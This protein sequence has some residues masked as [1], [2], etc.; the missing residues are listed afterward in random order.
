M[1]AEVPNPEYVMPRSILYSVIVIALLYMA[2]NFCI[3]IAAPWREAV[4]SKRIAGA[5]T[6]A[7]GVF[8][9]RLWRGKG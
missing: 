2:M 6:L 3:L 9:F 4:Q 1:W 8:A 7:A 5:G